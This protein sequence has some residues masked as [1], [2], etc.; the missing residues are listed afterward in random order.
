MG[1]VGGAR[2]RSPVRGRRLRPQRGSRP[3]AGIEREAAGH[4]RRAQGAR[5]LLPLQD[6]G[7]RKRRAGG[8]GVARRPL[9]E[10]VRRPDADERKARPARADDRRGGDHTRRRAAAC[11]RDVVRRQAR[12]AGMEARVPVLRVPAAVRTRRRPRRVRRAHGEEAGDRGR[13]HVSPA[14][15]R[16]RRDDGPGRARPRAG[17]GDGARDDRVGDASQRDRRHGSRQ[18]QL[19]R[20]DAP[21]G[22]RRRSGD[23]R[24]E[25][26]R[27][28]RRPARPRRGGRPTRRRRDRGRLGP[29]AP[30]SADRDDDRAH[31][32]DGV[33][34]PHAESGVLGCAPGGG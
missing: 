16:L 17:D 9:P 18:R 13:R 29:V 23:G 1:D 33:E 15:A 32:H 6:R 21:Q 2:G 11:R 27:R 28:R 14:A 8:R 19:P 4:V 22:A 34:R 10:G 7:A 26:C 24:I 31:P 20:G 3:R 25:R 12:R 30:R 5:S